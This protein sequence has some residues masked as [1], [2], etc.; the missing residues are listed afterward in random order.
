[1]IRSY[2][3]TWAKDSNLLLT[4]NIGKEKLFARFVIFVFFYSQPSLRC[5]VFFLHRNISFFFLLLLLY[6]IEASFH[7]MFYFILLILVPLRLLHIANVGRLPLKN[8]V[9]KLSRNGKWIEIN[10]Y[11]YNGNKNAKMV[12]TWVGKN[13]FAKWVLPWKRQRSLKPFCCNIF[14][15]T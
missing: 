5:W 14:G 15:L 7:F 3:Y 4:Y 6:S 13:N 2:I 12:Q 10:L 8:A 9:G 11:D 1:M